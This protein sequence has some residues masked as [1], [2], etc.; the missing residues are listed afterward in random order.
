MLGWTITIL[1]L[2]LIA[3]PFFFYLRERRGI[4]RSLAQPFP[5]AWRELLQRRLVLYRRLDDA[6]KLLLESRVRRF[7]AEKKFHGCNGQVVTEDMKVLI[8]GLACLLILRPSAHVYP[9]LR[10]ILVYPTAFWVRHHEPDEL[11]LV[12]DEAVEQVGESWEGDRIVVSWEDVQAALDGDPV[13]VVA[14]ECAHQLDDE[15]PESEGAPLLP[16][17]TRWS[18]VM[19]TAYDELCRRGSPVI[20]EYGAESPAE[21]FA[22]ATESYFQQGA[23]LRRHHPE[24][25]DLLK[26][27]YRVETV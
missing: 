5:E 21:F 2:G 6:Q 16:D 10:S 3:W 4:E 19:K 1:V 24:L 15:N 13:N 14:H 11:G 18:Q 22:V 17:Y 27:Y 23:D 20:D 8:A 12:S 26:D 7:V 9:R 25:Y